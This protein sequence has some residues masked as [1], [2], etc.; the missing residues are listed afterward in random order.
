MYAN[1]TVMHANAPL[2]NANAPLMHANAVTHANLHT[3]AVS[4]STLRP[5]A[6]ASNAPT[7]PNTQTSSAST[8]TMWNTTLGHLRANAQ[9][10][11]SRGLAAGKPA[12]ADVNLGA[13]HFI[14]HTPCHKSNL[15]T[16]KTQKTKNFW[17][18]TLHRR[19][20]STV[21]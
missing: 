21:H 1:A 13:L 15:N 7:H 18:Q 5:Y 17:V 4:H 12:K 14:V 2:M 19:E 11:A 8:S 3:N 20:T 9:T 10:V 16:P 6:P